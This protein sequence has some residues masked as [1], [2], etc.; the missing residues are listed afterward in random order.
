VDGIYT[1]DPIGAGD[2]GVLRLHGGAGEAQIRE[3]IKE[4]EK[5]DQR[6]DQLNMFK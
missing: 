6:L 3:Y 2:K 4:Q 1:D 5:E